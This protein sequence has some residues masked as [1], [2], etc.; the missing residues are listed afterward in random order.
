MEIL[1][2]EELVKNKSVPTIVF[3]SGSGKVSTTECVPGDLALLT[4]ADRQQLSNFSSHGLELDGLIF[5]TAEHAFHSLKCNFWGKKDKAIQFS[6][7]GEY[8][9]D[10]PRLL[11][12]YTGK[13]AKGVQ[14][15][16][17]QLEEWDK[18]STNVLIRVVSAKFKQ[19]SELMNLLRNKT[20]NA[21][22][23][24]LAKRRGKP[25]IYQRWL[26]LEKLR[27]EVN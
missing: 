27:D 22:L 23:V 12:K 15:S 25:S 19:N 13:G 3:W 4:A 16:P 10:E 17:E 26:F 5:A 18:E 7:K 6:I 21:R 8:G 20:K 2:K 14:V 11:K 1:D 24:H 9:Q